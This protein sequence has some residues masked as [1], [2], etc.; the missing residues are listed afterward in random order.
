MPFLAI[1]RFEPFLKAELLILRFFRSETY[2][3]ILENP[4]GDRIGQ[5]PAEKIDYSHILLILDPFLALNEH[6]TEKM[7][8]F[9]IRGIFFAY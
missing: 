2:N 6:F 1:F 7:A 3:I 5:I 4:F 9:A 8:V